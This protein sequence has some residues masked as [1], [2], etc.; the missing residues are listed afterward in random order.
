[1]NWKLLRGFLHKV[2]YYGSNLLTF[3]PRMDVDLR[4]F[5]HE[6][7]PGGRRSTSNIT[8]VRYKLYNNAV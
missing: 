3:W 5:I 1:M 8:Q 6:I 2:D 4:P 7:N